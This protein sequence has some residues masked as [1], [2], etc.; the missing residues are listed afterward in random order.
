MANNRSQLDSYEAHLVL[1]EK[2]RNLERLVDKYSKSKGLAAV[3]LRDSS[4]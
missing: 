1:L 3:H 2:Q 4:A